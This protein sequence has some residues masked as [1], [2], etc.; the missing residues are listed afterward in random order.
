MIRHLPIRQKVM[1]IVMLT[2]VVALVLACGALLSYEYR[3][4]QARL[5]KD[6]S[7][8]ADV[9]AA[10]SLAAVTFDDD[11]AA[12]EV[13]AG[14][15]ADPQIV[16]AYIFKNSGDLMATYVRAGVQLSRPD[17]PPPMGYTIA[18]DRLTF[19]T[20]LYD[21]AE[22]RSVAKVV[23]VADFSGIRQRLRSYALSLALVL[24]ASILVALT[25]SARLQRY[26]SGPILKL[27]RTTQLVSAQRDYSVRVPRETDDEFGQLI[28]GFNGML[29]QIQS[30]DVA[31]QAAHDNLEHRVQE[32]T[33]E[34]EQEVA[35]RM[36]A[37]EKLAD[38]LSLVT[39]TLESTADGILVVSNA[40]KV[41]S[42]NRKFLSLW[43]IPESIIAS[44]DDAPLIAYAANQLKDAEEF[45]AKIAYLYQHPNEDSYDTLEFTD[46]RI[47]ERYS[48][49][50]RV[51][52]NCV[53]RIWSFRDI[54]ARTKAEERIREQADLLDHAQD[55]I[56]VRDLN[57]IILYWNK[58]AERVY[59]W[60]IDEVIGSQMGRLFFSDGDKFVEAK[61]AT[62]ER[63]EWTGD[64][65]QRDKA[66][67]A[68]ITESRWTL[69]RDSAGKPKS[70]LVINT[71]ITERR[72]LEEQFLRAQRME[73][74]GTLAGGVAHDLNNVLAPILMSI[75]LLRQKVTHPGADQL[76]EA[77]QLSAQRGADLVRQILYF[78]R[79]VDGKRV[80]FPAERAIKEIYKIA[81]DTFPKN[82]EVR[83]SISPDLWPVFGDATQLH[84]VLLNLSVNARDAMPNGGALR[85]TAE[86]GS[87]EGSA[88]QVMTR[89]IAGP[90]ILIRISDNGMG[91]PEAIR[92]KI[93]EPFFTTKEIGRG[94][95]LGLSTVLAIVKGHRGVLEFDS[96]EGKGTVFSL[97]LPAVPAVQEEPESDRKARQMGQGET[98]LLVDDE[99]SVRLVVRQTLESLGYRVLSA[100]DGSTAIGLYLERM[101]EI[102]VVL[103]DMV[104]PGMDGAATIR[105]IKDI[106]P[107]AR[108]VAASGMITEERVTQATE[109]GAVAFLRKPYTAHAMLD[110]LHEALHS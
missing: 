92:E 40:G 15:G 89:P 35:E 53:G 79:G 106:N 101:E 63:G 60:R 36:R 4:Y 64:L 9:M 37:Q 2:A 105:A 107:K 28:N 7:T 41:V 48:Q 80:A 44:K 55:A 59:G 20:D 5:Q 97:Y 56:V 49:P 22:K 94:T 61:N 47:F 69:L 50:Q 71:D 12:E 74:I 45:R 70:M 32:R 30:R 13:L 43:R 34:L 25:L 26:I 110:A 109:A 51:S 57:D 66:G 16:A 58:G 62:I 93:F 23:L 33:A 52:G 91:I 108:I 73:S 39:A 100:S 8:L 102:A 96:E 27:A 10:N 1:A 67:R 31:L 14:L 87:E 75:E 83:C 90:H 88:A 65:E 103:T 95:G 3:E 19:A 17:G 42:F 18:N 21:T 84:Q 46:G 68:V 76:L 99:P 24:L 82:I 77:V 104:M 86:N 98:V 85:I 6:L 29:D 38:S 78:A 81:H 72:K 54:T 11:A